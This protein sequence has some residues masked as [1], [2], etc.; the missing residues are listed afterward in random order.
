MIFDDVINSELSGDVTNSDMSLKMFFRQYRSQQGS[1]TFNNLRM[2][3]DIKIL[4]LQNVAHLT[5]ANSYFRQIDNFE[6]IE[7]TLST[8]CHNQVSE[9]FYRKDVPCRKEALFY[10][11][12]YRLV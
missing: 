12:D 11:N 6:L 4:N 7:R 5:V 8:K 10:N 2:E 1:V 9:N 3:A